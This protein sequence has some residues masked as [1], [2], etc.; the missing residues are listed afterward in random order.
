MESSVATIVEEDPLYV[1]YGYEIPIED[2]FK[3]LQL[4]PAV[5]LTSK[6]V[7]RRLDVFGR[8]EIITPKGSVWEIYLA[9]LFDVLIVIYL[10]MT[11]ILLLFS[12]FVEGLVSKVSFW[13]VMIAFNMILAIFQQFRAQKKIEALQQLSP[14]K[15]K[16]I[17]NGAKGEIDAIN[18]V[19][20]DLIELSLG[21]RIPADARIIESS[22][23]TINEASLTG[24]SEPAEKLE[25]GS[26]PIDLEEPIAHHFNMLYLGCFVQ[27]GAAKAVVVRTGNYTELGKIA[28]AM[29][30]ISIEIPLRKRVNAL[31]RWLGI[32]MV[33]FL[34]ILLIFVT[35]RRVTDDEPF[36]FDQFAFDISQAIINAM[37]VLPINIPL[38]TTVILITGVLNMAKK[39]VIIKELSVVETLGRCSVLCSD[40]TGTMTTSKMTVRL[41][42]DTE[43][44][45]KVDLKE[46]FKNVLAPVEGDFDVLT[47]LDDQAQLEKEMEYIP[48]NS[49]LDLLMTSAILNNEATIVPSIDETTEAGENF[50]YEI[51]G[52]PTDGALLI[53]ARTNGLQINTIRKRYLKERVYPFDSK[54]KRMSGLFKDTKEDDLMVFSKGATEV[55]LPRCTNIGSEVNKQKLTKKR[56]NELQKKVDEFANNGYRVIS[57]AYKP[58]DELPDLD[59][60]E[61][62]DFIESD[63]TYIG[64]AIIY[65]PPRPGVLQAVNDLD[66]AGIFPIMITGDAPTT[67]ATI[68]RQV[69]ILDPDEIVVEGKEA[70]ILEDS[71]F[72]KVSVFARVSP[73]DKEIIVSRYKDRGDIVAMTGDGVND[74]LA[75]TTSDA[76]V[77]MGITG[78]EVAKEAADIIIS[79][80]S[81]VS[82]VKGVE[83]GRNLYEK[84]RMLIFF[85]IAVNLAEAI[86][87]FTAS[88]D[89][90]FQIVN[91]WQRVYIFSIIHSVPVL[92]I[93]FGPDDKNIMTLKPR[94]NDALLPKRLS[95]ALA[96]FSISL[97]LGIL[98]VYYF[99]L[100]ND[101][102]TS[103][104]RGGYSIENFKPIGTEDTDEQLW[105]ENWSHAKARTMFLTIVYLAES[106]LILSIRRINTDVFTGSREDN[107]PLVWLLVLFG[108][109]L[110]FL[111]L[112]ITPLQDGLASSGIELELVRLNIIDLLIC[113]SAAVLPLTLLELYKWYNR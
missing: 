20:G 61:I 102:V 10:V 12:F 36:S 28:S 40:K 101:F 92:A 41:L 59:S 57:L 76:G 79:D 87:Y 39:R 38:L 56:K 13:L 100:N 111:L 24:E 29:S 31:G 14:P 65:D 81:Y 108:P 23:L 83:E 109:V 77:A 106:F 55:I 89:I 74:A 90:D 93:I 44:H 3:Q 26:A 88:F 53:L 69:G 51:I 95:G 5:G 78:T 105:P 30:D 2:V 97:A 107:D 73:Q 9:P 34:A 80:D 45:Y 67:A 66:S 6:D 35:Y 1:Q 25:D 103:F 75:I 47:V 19:P 112:Y 50:E 54:V 49:P 42:Y 104:N 11:G 68:A 63:L 72:F 52:N 96:I 33:S 22:N 27:T 7:E 48:S 32:M 99:F 70:S 16:A 21:D 4:D 82:L 62:R 85:Y 91:N 71:D 113:F 43:T 37:A 86:V 64:F 17:R 58:V 110:H 94:D 60:K 18:L 8:N 98:A 15:A 46:N 84:I